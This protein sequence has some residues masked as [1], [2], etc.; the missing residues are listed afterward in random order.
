MAFFSEA[1][2][3]LAQKTPLNTLTA[4]SA[5]QLLSMVA[6]THG[7]DDIA[8]EYLR[9]GVRLGRLMGLFGVQSNAAS[10]N[11]WADG[12]HDWNIATSYT[13]WGVFN[14]VWYVHSHL[15]PVN[16]RGRVTYEISVHSLHYQRAEIDVPPILPM[17]GEVD[18][19]VGISNVG[20]T[21]N[22]LDTRTFKA[23]CQLWSI[24]NHVLWA[25]YGEKTIGAPSQRA[26]LSFAEEIYGQLLFWADCLPLE[27]VRC[28]ESTHAV[29]LMQ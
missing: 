16:G 7:R 28:Q 20:D 22:Y 8:L 19:G 25:Y 26:S 2:A 6:V 21:T 5:F 17:P 12:H 14:W 10:A 18:T 24:F 1:E 11:A 13:A 9:E 27:L 23:C 3:L 15:D 4:V 29:F